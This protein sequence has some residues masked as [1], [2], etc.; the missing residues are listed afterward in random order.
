MIVGILAK[1]FLG[2]GLSAIGDQLNRAYAA[3]LA[4]TTSEATL[5]A[6]KEIAL[7][8]AKREV[9]LAEVGAGGLR[10]WIRPLFALPFVIYIWK[11]VVWDKVLGYGSTDSLSPDLANIMMLIIGAYF[12]DRTV[13]AWTR[14]RR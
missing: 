14:M 10:S 8:A 12:L 11:L 5:A 7:L 1:F 2:G 13:K 4:A 3:K 9:L 6:E